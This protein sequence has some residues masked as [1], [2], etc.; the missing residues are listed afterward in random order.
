LNARERLEALESVFAALAHA[1]R[2]Q[3]L[4][5]VYFREGMSAGDIAKRFHYAWP[6]ISRHLRVLED[7]R[8]L[9]HEKKGRQRLYR[10]DHDRL[11]LA[12][13]WLDWFK[14]RRG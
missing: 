10:V 7:A 3:I 9:V 11:G 1:S 12:Q 6:T 13:E 5:T 8:L 14:G 4:M 2:R